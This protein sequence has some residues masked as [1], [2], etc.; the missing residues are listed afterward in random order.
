M[1]YICI[2]INEF[3]LLVSCY[4]VLCYGMNF[5]YDVI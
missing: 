4:V 5:V 2:F 3:M 1:N